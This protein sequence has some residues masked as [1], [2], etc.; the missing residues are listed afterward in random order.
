M[1]ILFFIGRL[2]TG[3]AQSQLVEL[4]RG[5][6]E[7]GHSVAAWSIFSGG[8]IRQRLEGVARVSSGSLE[9]RPPAG[10][11]GTTSAL[12]MAPY[13][14]RRVIRSWQPDVVYSFLYPSSAIAGLAVGGTPTVP[15]VFGV[16]AAGLELG[17]KTAPFFWLCARLSRR[18][19]LTLA[20]SRVGLAEHR[21]RGFSVERARVVPNGIDVETFAPSTRL[22]QAVRLEL[23][24]ADSAF[25]L[26]RVARLAPIK[27]HPTLLEAAAL[28]R[29]RDPGIVLL[30]VGG[31]KS[32]YAA[33][34]RD[35]AAYHGVGA[36]V[37]WV[38]DREDMPAVYN[39]MDIVVSNSRGEGFPNVVAEAMACGV[40]CVCTDVGESAEVIGP[41]G[42][43]VRPG[44][45]ADL[46]ESVAA[47][48]AHRP[49]A[50]ACRSRIRERFSVGSMVERTESVLREVVEG[51]AER[52]GA[53]NSVRDR[54]G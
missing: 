48:R 40:P 4:A 1:R 37:L 33:R 25:V 17:W 3:G 14:L 28:L 9:G 16:R 7:R 50:Q 47:L 24:I 49:S 21:E 18:A 2:E 51:A 53:E 42:L 6:A 39:A 41:T 32:A 11:V 15:W 8:R 26:G 34:L 19:A 20:N 46:A 5:L 43:L 23:G 35:L 13:R 22:R 45:A 54:E 31:G 10:W 44:I 12:A 29:A 27:D 30:C 38:G 52:Q 36:N